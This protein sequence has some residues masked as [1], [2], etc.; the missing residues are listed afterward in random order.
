[1]PP[2]RY[3]NL[4]RDGVRRSRMESELKRLRLEGERHAAVLWSALQPSEQTRLYDSRLN[5]R[6][7][8]LPLV[9]GEKG[10]YASHLQVWQALL[11]SDHE[12]LV[13]LEDDVRLLDPFGEVCAAVA[14]L[15]QPW[16]MVKLM[17]REGI[18]KPEKLAACQ[19]LCSGHTLVSYRRLPSLT[20][21]YVLHRR[22][23]AKLLAHRVPFGRPIDVDLRHWW[24]CDR[25][26]VFGVH[27]AVIALDETSEQSSIGA[28]LR[29]LPM[30]L[31]WR[32]FLHKAR[33]SMCNAWHR[34]RPTGRTS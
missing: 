5:A 30:A 26:Q 9:A 2:L 29:R 4:D 23:A 7:H 34:L 16:D 1:M 14:K 25:L 28:E 27:P 10:C 19:P 31:R 18:G 15:A 22:G 6:Q 33:Y 32:K 20:A 17:G 11:D 3:I 8:H 12:C 24:E 21:G 13:V